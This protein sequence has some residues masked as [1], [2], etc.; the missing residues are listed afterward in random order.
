MDVGARGIR[1]VTEDYVLPYSTI[2]M[3]YFTVYNRYA[4]CVFRRVT[5]SVG[6]SCM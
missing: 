5:A 4:E 3:R 1:I 2:K 6:F